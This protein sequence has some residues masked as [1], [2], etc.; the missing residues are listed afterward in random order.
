[1]NEFPDY[2]FFCSLKITSP[3]IADFHINAHRMT[4]STKKNYCVQ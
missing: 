2:H 4:E 3:N 1:M